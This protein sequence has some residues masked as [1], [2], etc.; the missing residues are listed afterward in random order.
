MTYTNPEALVS[1]EWLADHMSAPDV[2]IVDASYHLP[3]TNRDPRAEYEESHIP[4]AVFF[5]ISDICDE[6]NDLPHML[7]SPEK[8][9]SRV[10]KLGLGDGNSIVV[11]DANGGFSAAARVWWMFRVFGHVDV[12]VLD[13]S[14]PKW[15]AEG[16]PTDDR[17]PAP[18][19]R[20]FT[21]QLNH[22]LVRD[23]GHL[24]DNI[25]GKRDQVLDARPADRYAGTGEETRPNLRKGHI[26]GSLNMPFSGL[27]DPT[28]HFVMRPADELQASF[29]SID[30]DLRRPVV[31]LCGS[32]VTAAVLALSLYLIGH[33]HAAIYDGSW[34]EWGG[35]DDTPIDP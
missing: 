3:A 32:G 15:L 13:G 2:R 10:R 22:I 28:A 4:G 24:L 21:A 26:P 25:V 19:P 5:D 20:H 11:Y 14:L 6:N 33:K 8:F 1:T 29:G 12:A 18:S 7:P 9:A 27:M 34:S 23:M 35:R 30:V 16:R 31:A 17:E